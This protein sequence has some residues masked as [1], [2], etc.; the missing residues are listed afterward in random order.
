MKVSLSAL[1]GLF[2]AKMN[3]GANATVKAVDYPNRVH[4]P[5]INLDTKKRIY[6][7]PDDHTDYFWTRGEADYRQA[8]IEMINYYL[9]LADSTQGNQSEYQSR[10]NCDGS[11]WLYVYEKDR[12]NDFNRLINRIR[13][14]HI[15]APL[16]AL[17]VCL[18]GAPSEAVIR[19][20]YYPGTLERRFDIRF[21]VAI[22]ME[23]QT[24]PYGLISL[25][26]GSGAQYSWKGICGCD[27]QVPSA[28]DREHDIYWA[29]GP[30]GQKILMKWN[31]MLM[32]N[33]YPGGYAEARDPASSVDFVDQDAEFQRRYPY[34]V[35]GVFGKGWDD[36]KT[37]T[38]EFVTVAMN[39]SDDARQ[40]IVSNQVDFFQ[41]FNQKYGTQI[42]SVSCSYGNEWD[43]YC[44][45]MAETSAQVKRSTEKLRSAEALA[46][47][48]SS[49]SPTFMD[50]RQS[51]REKAWMALGLYWEHNFGMVGPQVNLVNERIAW[52]KRLANDLRTY[53][54][55]LQTDAVNG[56][57]QR[58]Q[59]SGANTRF[60]AFNPLSW[61]RDGVADF[62]YNGGTPVH[63]I[64][65]TSQQEVPSQIVNLGGTNYLRILAKGI[66]AVGY[67]AFEIKPGAGQVFSN[68]ATVNGGVIENALLK[69]TVANR[70]AIT[71]L[72]D[73]GLNKEFVRVVNGRAINDL[74]TG[75]GTL[76]AE[77]Q[78]PVSVTV[79]AVSSAPL[80]HTSRITLV[81][82]ARAI[83]IQNDITQNFDNVN[84]WGFGFEI[85]S[86]DVWHEEV[87]A[88]IRAKKVSQGGHYSDR[89]SNSRYDWLTLNHFADVSA[90]NAGITLSNMDCYFMKLGNSSVEH[91]DTTTPLINVLAGG[92]VV[93]AD[94]GLPGQ[95]GDTN[96]LQRFALQPHGAYDSLQAMKFAL[97][98]QNPLVTGQITG[99]AVSLPETQYSFLQINNPSVL[100]WALK[101]A[102]DGVG[103]GLIARV[104]NI[105]S[106]GQNFSLK[107]ND[108][109]LM[110]AIQ[111]THIETPVATAQVTNGDLIDNLLPQQIKT[112]AVSRTQVFMAHGRQD[113]A[114]EVKP[115]AAPTS[116]VL[117]PTVTLAAS[118]PTLQNTQETEME[119]EIV[120]VSTKTP[121]VTVRSTSLPTG[122]EPNGKG[123]V[124]G[125]L[126]F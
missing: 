63:V 33:V 100:L 36:F 79:K 69:V 60:F 40:V 90:A 37:L 99:T 103:A 12:P 23:N 75:S 118:E 35:I 110:S 83:Y 93:Y 126:G 82:D 6:I 107:L 58:I 123:C 125:L 13:D 109:P 28:W 1:A 59:K 95:G 2:L 20:M 24:L 111:V 78:G 41:S 55:K 108:G 113:E 97:E 8:F 30:D 9:N 53:V 72:V 34:Q 85:S 43:L 11:Y 39:K 121:I 56:I 71:G 15:S 77:N 74:G 96:F 76:S 25:W 42:P 57:G 65:L 86:P 124:L 27:T 102:E 7:A 52:Q 92:R 67:K 31:S 120:T 122:S 62:P 49:L 46:A 4:L 80:A 19:G 51:D 112:Y 115:E 14:G 70:G 94:H 101:P 88:I 68:A 21:P 81:R 45:A 114:L 22:A 29:T 105:S 16:N 117:L 26:R 3:H 48:L 18:G 119:A 91:L 44:A 106:A 66:P 17:V 116:T 64:D 84:T 10:W 38:N 32:G 50:G 5:V 54:D 98:H 87:G 47:I 73:K 61:A 104:W 89:A